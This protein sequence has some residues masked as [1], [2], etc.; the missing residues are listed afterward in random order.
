MK[1]PLRF[2]IGSILIFSSIMMLFFTY[3]PVLKAYL[4]YTQPEIVEAASGFYISIPKINAFAPIVLNINPWNKKEY[5]VALEK[6]VAQAQGSAM[7]GQEGSIYLFAHSS[8]VPWRITRYN[9]A[10]LRLGE[11]Q[12]GDEINI[13]KGSHQYLFVVTDK[14]EIWPNQTDVLKKALSSSET[15]GSQLLILQTCT[16]VGTD[17]KRLLVFAIQK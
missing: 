4:P 11:L 15:E 12:N 9:T 14:E 17:L 1:K 5:L 2:Y 8:D 3:Y 6:G 16:P 7:P 10:F 13:T